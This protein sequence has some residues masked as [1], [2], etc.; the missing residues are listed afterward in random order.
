[1]L[2]ERNLAS[3]ADNRIRRQGR[4]GRS[5][6]VGRTQEADGFGAQDP[7]PISRA[8]SAVE[9]KN[10][11]R[12]I[13]G[14]RNLRG[15]RR[16]K[17]ARRAQGQEGCGR[18][19]AAPKAAR[20]GEEDPRRASKGV[21][22]G[23]RNDRESD[24]R[25]SGERTRYRPSRETLKTGA[26]SDEERARVYSAAPKPPVRLKALEGMNARPLRPIPYLTR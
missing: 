19:A 13:A 3:A 2:R 17:L 4:P 23:A 25:E 12:A 8:A 1:M 7:K 11:R 22:R 24:D 20:T 16:C 18:G 15:D 9:T 6:H 10:L 26:T 14:G 21:W 5:R